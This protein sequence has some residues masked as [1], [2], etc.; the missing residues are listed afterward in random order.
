MKKH[1]D[2]FI[3]SKK[4]KVLRYCYKEIEG[5]KAIVF[6]TQIKGQEFILDPHIG[7]EIVIDGAV[8]SNNAKFEEALKFTTCEEW[9][10]R[11]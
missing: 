5:E 9:I 7:V 11:I 4:I 8:I 2:V 6:R 1:I 3:N 10:Y